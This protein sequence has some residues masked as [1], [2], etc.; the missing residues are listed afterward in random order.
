MSIV[1]DSGQL[2]A[3][4]YIPTRAIGFIKAGQPV[5]L[6]YD[7]F[8]YQKYGVYEGRIEE[9]TQ[10]IFSPSELNIPVT[11]NEPVY[12]VIVALHDDAIHA[13]GQAF[14]LQPGMTLN[15]QIIYDQRTLLEWVLEPIYSRM[16][17]A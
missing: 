15:A 5:K 9:I 17:N 2:Q 4:L 16:G 6:Q 7:A 8:P 3:H 10:T 14:A 13:F 12:R 11:V 1:P